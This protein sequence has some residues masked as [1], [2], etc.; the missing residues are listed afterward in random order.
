MSAPHIPADRV[1]RVE[2]E[3]LDDRG[4]VRVQPHV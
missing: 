2:V 3:Q 4:R 1:G